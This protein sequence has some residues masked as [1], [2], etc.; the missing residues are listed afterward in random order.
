MRGLA[1]IVLLGLAQSAGAEPVFTPGAT[2][3]CLA[4]PKG[5]AH[6]Q[7]CV[8]KAAEAC[9]SPP[10]VYS[11]V[12]IGYCLGQEANYWDGR[13]NAAYSRLMTFE[14]NLMDEMIEIGATVPDAAAALRDM[15]RAWITYRDAACG[16]EYATFGGGTGGGPAHAACTMNLTASQALALETHLS[17]RG[18]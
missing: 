6:P 11:N 15:Q 14:R 5:Q 10:G 1:V 2:E 8:G 17:Q 9:Y 16:Y 18:P 12:A 3:T 7:D 4:T 13:L